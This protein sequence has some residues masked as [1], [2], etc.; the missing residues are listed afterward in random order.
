MVGAAPVPVRQVYPN[1]FLTEDPH[2]L[3]A[4][5]VHR[6]R[7]AQRDVASWR[8]LPPTFETFVAC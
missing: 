7:L 4:S 2:H 1:K 8:R 6:L 3:V 5:G